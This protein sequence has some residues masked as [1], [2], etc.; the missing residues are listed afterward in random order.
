MFINEEKDRKIAIPEKAIKEVN[1]GKQ[2]PQEHEE[3]IIKLL[4]QKYD[5]QVELFKL[6]DNISS[7]GFRKI[8]IDY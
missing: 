4:K 5:S 6:K 3:N 8:K 2:I 1:L 7:Y